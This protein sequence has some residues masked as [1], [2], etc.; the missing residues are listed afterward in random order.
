M[1][2]LMLACLLL[3]MLAPSCENTGSGSTEPWPDRIDLVVIDSAGTETGD[4]SFGAIGDVCF[5]S[6]GRILVL[7][8]ARGYVN[9]YSREGEAI[10][11]VGGQGSGPGELNLP[12]SIARLGDGRIFVL[13][14]MSNSYELFDGSDYSYLEEVA[15]WDNNP[16]MDPCGLDGDFYIGLKFEMDQSDGTLTGLSTLGR[17]RMGEADPQVIYFSSEFPV[18]PGDLG[19]LV[20]NML[21]SVVFTGDPQGRIFYSEMSTQ[22]YEITACGID[23]TELFHITADISPVSRSTEEMD[24]EKAYM[25]HWV[26]RMGGMNGMP[27][28]WKPEP[29]RWMVSGLG[30]DG[31][32]R[33]WVQRGTETMPVFDVFDMTGEHIFSV[34]LPREGM[35]WRFHIESEGMLAWE[36]DPENG[37]QKVFVIEIP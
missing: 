30:V 5:D 25:E 17:F 33:L 14:P 35:D 3:A 7:D 22:N 1:K 2:H 37:V 6:Q 31:R 15:L 13:D 29:C 23:G 24:E 11:L 36:E 4:S 18:D 28:E 32:Q 9:V 21:R 27:I 10:T 12:L 16:P 34:R 19:S 8:Q 26:S 20:K